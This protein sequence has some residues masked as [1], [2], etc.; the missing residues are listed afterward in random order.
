MEISKL[1]GILMEYERENPNAYVYINYE[2]NFEE[3]IRVHKADTG[4]IL[5]VPEIKELDL[6]E[7]Q[8]FFFVDGWNI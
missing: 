5:L 3:E 4:N 8:E 6:C 2:P 1:I 7:N